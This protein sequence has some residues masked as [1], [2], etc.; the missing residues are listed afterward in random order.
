MTK[1]STPHGNLPADLTP[2][3][4]R[5]HLLD[6]A[7]PVLTRS[8]L[9][10]L[11]GAGGV[12][13]TRAA[14]HLGRTY[15]LAAPGG[16]WLVDL[17]AVD[18]PALVPHAVADALGIHDQ[19][20]RRALDAITEHVRER[21]HLLLILDNCEHLTP[22]VAQLADALL[23]H[24][25]AVR[26]LATSRHCLGV[27][28]EHS[29]PVEPMSVPTRAE[30]AGAVSLDAIGH[31]DAVRLFLDRAADAGA[32]ISDLDAEAIGRLVRRV[33]GVPL[34][35]EL[36]AA[37]TATRTVA[38]VLAHLDDPLRTLAGTGGVS[39]PH[40][41]ASVDATLTWSYQQCTP[42]E[43]RLWARLSVFTGGFDLVAAE[44]I[45]SDDL[46]PEREIL[47]LIEG[48]AR[49]SLITIRRTGA[50][51]ASHV[52][53]GMLETVRAYGRARL[54]E[55]GE[56][57]QIHSRH[58][59]YYRSLTSRLLREWYGPRE[60][61]WMSCIRR[62]M[63]NIRAALSNSVLTGDAETGLAITLNLSRS[64]V[65]FFVGTMP[66]ARYWL[67]TL[68]AL[69]P[70]TSLLL[71]VM[72]TGA[73]IA[74]SQGDR[75]AA[76]L[77]IGDCLRAGRNPEAGAED[78][79]ASVIAFAKGA[80]QL[81][82]GNDFARAAR[83]FAHARDGLLRAGFL[84]DAHMARVCLT[85]AAAAGSDPQAAFR[86][87]EE[88][89]AD[90]DASSAPWAG[91]WATWAHGLVDLRHGDPEHA[92]RRFRAGLRIGHAA[93]DNWGPAWSLASIGWALAALGEHDQAAVLMGAADRH[94]QRIGIDTTRLA[95]LAT[96]SQTARND[97]R[98]ALGDAR[99]GVAHTHGAQLDYHEAVAT[100][101]GDDAGPPQN[102][103]TRSSTG[104]TPGVVDAD[105]SSNAGNSAETAQLTER[106]WTVTRLL[107]ADAG[108]TNKELAGRLYV[109]VRTVEAHMNDIMRKLGVTSRAEVAVWAITHDP[110]FR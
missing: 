54:A 67:R 102:T 36:A 93:G 4:G 68:L 15:P 59:S 80:Y 110:Q 21:G 82:C 78:I 33:E 79:T 8:R 58:R 22:A 46:L 18:E 12:G 98:A 96:L 23:R 42:A 39:H 84:G 83:N 25:P 71:L 108:L 24:A 95:M 101:L 47:T 7:G 29:V 61:E 28:G 69:C 49:Q 2:F 32:G 85:V 38:D 62:E 64:R 60:L 70:D 50:G 89:S 51:Q 109:N 44:A 26:I 53:Y 73:W 45:C 27:Q 56:Q 41:H 88:C 66:E 86:A 19:T 87:A 81:F 6:T 77:I 94:L 20:R 9:V 1:R 74:S 48:L 63:P 103:N 3:V 57:A 91:S 90:A 5:R 11:L 100:A 43:Q 35:I 13:K 105:G 14:I 10:T 99:H 97:A 17:A 107:G 40:H 31:H 55:H 16:V 104:H 37:R 76:L 72:G 52:R 65:W 75:R 34:A 106:E 92:L 30:L